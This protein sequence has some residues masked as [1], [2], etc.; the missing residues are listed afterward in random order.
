VIT[1]VVR[2]LID[3]E[4]AD[5]LVPDVVAVDVEEGVDMADVFAVRLAVVVRADGS[6]SHVDDPR[7]QV[8]KRLTVEAGYADA[9][10]T[11]IDGY[12]TGVE[13]FL[14]GDQEPYLELAGM[15]AT[16]LMDLEDKQLAWPNKKDHEIAQE[17]F[18]GYGLSHEVEDTL[19]QHAEAVSTVLQSETDIRFLRRLAARNGFECHVKGARGF[20]RG[21]NLQDPPQK[22]VAL[23]A[24]D[25]ASL[26]S[27]TTR[28]DGTPATAPEVRRVD[29]VE[30]Q[31][32]VK[33][34]AETPR[35]RLGADTLAGLR[36]D[37]PDGRVLLRRQAPASVTEMEAR[38][39]GAYE[40]ATRF[41]V[42]EG[43]VD[44]RAYRAVLRARGLVTVKGIGERYSGLWYVTRVRHA[45]TADGYTQRFEA[46]RNGLGPTGEERFAA[47][48]LPQPIAAGTQA[49][50]S[51]PTG[52]RVLPAQQ[53]G[54][55][56]AGGG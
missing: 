20:F 54:S 11:V 51:R 52:N 22:T 44:A 31:E 3:G 8:W 32:E 46:Y 6:W 43:E 21:P 56:L 45:F 1:E 28:V 13:V 14:S 2:I 49:G 36:G 40:G 33:H 5:D 35:R 50:V 53:A 27:V 42:L 7:F 55:A 23:G 34:L 41:V 30:K 18:G 19:V 39:R 29:P 37:L 9:T 15:D 38:L 26:V 10:E 47:A 25:D 16:A 12:V 24:G 4:P 17:I 48:V